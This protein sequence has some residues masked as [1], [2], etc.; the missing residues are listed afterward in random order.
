MYAT[1]PA[2]AAIGANGI[3]I[4]P[5]A[6]NHIA[7]IVIKKFYE[8]G[9]NVSAFGDALE[10]NILNAIRIAIPRGMVL[11][12]S[13]AEDMHNPL[14][15]QLE[16]YTYV[17]FSSIDSDFGMAKM[18]VYCRLSVMTKTLSLRT[19]QRNFTL[20]PKEPVGGGSNSDEDYEPEDVYYDEPEYYDTD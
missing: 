8:M 2:L 11:T 16:I 6:A 18:K 3:R 5:N 14:D 1:I 17:D 13:S 20:D 9:K 7:S 19:I 10:K 4:T 12:A 15:R